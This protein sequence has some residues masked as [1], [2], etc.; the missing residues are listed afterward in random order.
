MEFLLRIF[1]QF[2]YTGEFRRC[3]NDE[4]LINVL[5]WYEIMYAIGINLGPGLPILFSFVNIHIGWWTINEN[6]II[7]VIIV[8]SVSIIFVFGWFYVIDLSKELDSIKAEFLLYSKEND[9]TVVI[10]NSLSIEK[11]QFQKDPVSESPKL[12]K[13]EIPSRSL[14]KVSERLLNQQDCSPSEEPARD[15]MKWKDL[16]QLDILLLAFSYG[17]MRSTVAMSLTDVSLIATNTFGWKMN[18]LAWLHMII[19]SLSYLFILLLVKFEIFKPRRTI[20]YSYVVGGCISLGMLSLL[21]LPKALQF[22]N[23]PSQIAFGG[24]ILFL[25]CHVYFQAQSSG[26]FLVFNTASF[27]NANFVDGFRSFVGNLFKI[28]AKGTSFYS[29]LYTEYFVPPMFTFGLLIFALLLTRE[30]T[31]IG[32][33]STAKVSHKKL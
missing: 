28:F 21:M 18:T 17:F 30:R 9:K 10:L 14:S 24:S 7:P 20:F 2:S 27:D 13:A 6:N 22:P 31:H 5:G 8:L 32:L 19:G 11:E 1:K 23:L 29:F 25:K 4:E 3:Y 16:L 15:L 33:T 12:R 26:K